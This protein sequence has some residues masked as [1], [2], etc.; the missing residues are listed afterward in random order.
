MPEIP[1]FKLTHGQVAWAICQGRESDDQT[2]DAL[3]YLRQLG[4]PFTEDERG[5]GR[6]NRLHYT[7][8][9]LI[10]CSVAMFAIRHGMKPKMAATF[11]TGERAILRQL[12][13]REFRECPDAALAADWVKSRG[14][15]RPIMQ[16]EQFIRLHERFAAHGG[17]IE[18]MTLD[19]VV[20]YHASLGDMVERYSNRVY[21]LV[22][23]KRVML[24][25]VAWA[26]EAPVT[27]PGRAPRRDTLTVQV[28][29][30]N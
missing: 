4:V 20:S 1:R 17:K 28:P 26:L 23:L 19:E 30:P 8:D 6:G 10:E 18:M 2:I 3:R 14:T 21:P 29:N 5:V 11:L 7:F 12:Y 16:G 9:H 25:V 24:E 15:I 27:P 13:R 22:P